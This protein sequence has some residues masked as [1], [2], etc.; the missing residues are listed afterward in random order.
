MCVC[1]SQC[2]ICRH[3]RRISGPPVVWFR[4]CTTSPTC[5]P[6]PRKPAN[7]VQVV[8][9]HQFSL[10]LCAM[11]EVVLVCSFVWISG[12]LLFQLNDRFITTFIHIPVKLTLLNNTQKKKHESLR[13]PSHQ[14]R[15]LLAAINN[16]VIFGLVNNH[17][18]QFAVLCSG[19][20][21]H[22]NHLPNE[23]C[24]IL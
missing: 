15:G 12:G 9:V 8:S 1:S 11:A 10:V 6:L 4:S 20:Q 3:S 23:H 24:H 18:F 5:S 19:S 17:F 14:L 13:L 2:W 22:L 21:S 7:T 16:R